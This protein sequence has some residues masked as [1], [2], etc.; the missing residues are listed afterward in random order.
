MKR[1]FIWAA[2]LALSLCAAIA[3]TGCESAIDPT[4]DALN[5][6]RAAAAPVT[7]TGPLA[8]V[9]GEYAVLYQGNPWYIKGLA[10]P[11]IAEGSNLTVTGEASPILDR[12][13]EDNSLFYGYYLYVF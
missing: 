1:S 2:A 10:N 9:D 11:D 4:A 3:L 7:I 6:G 12:D 8:V 13:D 5:V